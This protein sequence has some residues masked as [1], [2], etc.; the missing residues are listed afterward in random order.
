MAASYMDSTLLQ[1]VEGLHAVEVA[2][3][4]VWGPEA[5]QHFAAL[6]A[7]EIANGDVEITPFFA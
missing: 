7:A 3:A 5:A 1:R 2:V 4:S 6:R